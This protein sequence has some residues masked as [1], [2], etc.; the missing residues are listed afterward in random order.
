MVKYHAQAIC[1]PRILKTELDFCTNTTK[2]I[3]SEILMV[4]F[5]ESGIWQLKNVLLIRISYSVKICIFL[6][7]ILM[8]M[9]EN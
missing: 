3:H 9:C 5:W 6:S 2:I 1:K 7:S 8:Y 4:S